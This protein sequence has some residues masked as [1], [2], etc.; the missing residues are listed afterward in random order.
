M[1]AGL[2]HLLCQGKSIEKAAMYGVASGT[3][4]TMNEGTELCK[5]EDVER[6]YAYIKSK[7]EHLL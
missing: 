5:K 1:V 7:H 6:L 4:A 3:A 2:I